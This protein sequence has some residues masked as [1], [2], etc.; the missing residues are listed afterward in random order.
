MTFCGRDVSRL[1]VPLWPSSKRYMSTSAGTRLL[2][3]GSVPTLNDDVSG[4]V[5][6]LKVRSLITP[7]LVA[8]ANM[9]LM[10]V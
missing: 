10:S 5:R 9:E 1:M 6:I 7:K 8:V 2:E 4:L 3:P